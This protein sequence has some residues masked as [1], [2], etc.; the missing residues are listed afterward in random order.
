MPDN[1]RLTGSFDGSRFA[2]DAY[3]DAPGIGQFLFDAARD[4]AADNR[5]FF[6]VDDIGFD[7]NADFAPGLDG[8]TFFDALERQAD[9]FDIFEPFDVGFEDFAARAGA[10]AR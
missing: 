6:V 10:G 1:L 5:R 7:E 2:D 9:F 8:I 3:F 4:I